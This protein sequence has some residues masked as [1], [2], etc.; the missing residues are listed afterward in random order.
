MAGLVVAAIFAASMDPNLNSM[1]TLT[2]CDIYQRY[3]RPNAGQRESMFVL[4]ASTLFWGALGTGIA[5]ALIATG[6]TVLENWWK[7]A[8]IFSGG[9]LGL[10]LLGLVS[11]RAGPGRR[12]DRRHP[13]RAR[14][15][16]DDAPQIDRRAGATSQPAAHANDDRRRHAHHLPRR[17]GNHGSPK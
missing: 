16:L 17:F 1:A 2:L 10:F 8:S 14:D 12:G 11:R 9:V 13:G 6:D 5:L 7:L 15:R 4:R 3:F